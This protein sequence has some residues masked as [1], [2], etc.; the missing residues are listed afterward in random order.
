MEY[1]DTYEG[2]GDRGEAVPPYL[3][4]VRHYESCLE[5]FGPTYQG[6][7]WPNEAD[8]RVRFDVMLDLMRDHTADASSL[9]DLGCG[10]GLLLDHLNMRLPH[11]GGATID[12]QGIDLSQP[13][14][15]AARSRHPSG[16]FS[17]R[18]VLINPIA[19]LSVDYVVMNG[20][21][22]EK[23]DL[24]FETME[25]FA[26]NLIAAAFHSARKGIAFNVMSPFVDWQRDDLFHWPMERMVAAIQGLSRHIVIRADYGLR[27]YTTYLYRDAQIDSSG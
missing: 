16:N 12:Y 26:T 10:P 6:V 23:R 8:L 1:K 2:S 11:S 21:M 4:L 19:P 22:T 5:K 15:D 25:E 24:T 27:E 3:T 9:L 7:D 18:N 13:M 14:I 20:V 17:V